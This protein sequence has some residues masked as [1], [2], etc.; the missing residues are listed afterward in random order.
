M[1]MF[2][3]FLLQFL[4]LR[5][6]GGQ[7]DGLSLEIGTV[8][9]CSEQFDVAVI[10]G[11]LSSEPWIPLAIFGIAWEIDK[12]DLRDVR[13]HESTENAHVQ[14][15]VFRSPDEQGVAQIQLD[16]VVL[17]CSPIEPEPRQPILV[18]TFGVVGPFLA[19]DLRLL[20]DYASGH[21]H[22][23][24]FNPNLEPIRPLLVNGRVC[25]L[26]FLR[27]DVDENGTLELTDAVGILGH[28]FLES[29]VPPRCGDIADVNDDGRLDISD[30][31]YLLVYLFQGGPVPSAPAVTAGLDPTPDNIVCSEPSACR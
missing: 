10:V 14:P 5:S 8:E 21:G 17:G 29:G 23:V 22:S 9:I 30:P 3:L 25:V 4:A 11:G 18:L 1:I 27:G 15:H 6:L 31:V 12:V 20:A 26:R 2:G 7:E 19:T 24:I 13:R 28:L 16:C